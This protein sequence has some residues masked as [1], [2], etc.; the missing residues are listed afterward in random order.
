MLAE[1][2]G[3]LEA[4]VETG[5]VNMDRVVSIVDEDEKEKEVVA[6]GKISVIGRR[7]DVVVE[8]AMKTQKRICK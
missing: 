7:E 6:L 1:A 2:A 5:V 3:K 8:D 4:M